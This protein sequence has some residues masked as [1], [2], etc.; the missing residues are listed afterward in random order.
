MN[1]VSAILPLFIV[2]VVVDARKQIPELP[3]E[4]F[5]K[6]LEENELQ[7]LRY[8]LRVS[9]LLYSSNLWPE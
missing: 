5:G 8:S 7:F 3:F 1:C 6:I 2:Y 4:K 9:S